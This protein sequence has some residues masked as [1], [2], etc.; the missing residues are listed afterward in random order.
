MYNYINYDCCAVLIIRMAADTYIIIIYMNENAIKNI[1]VATT[2][3]INEWK[4]LWLI[5][6][7]MTLDLCGGVLY[8]SIMCENNT[9]RLKINPLEL[10]TGFTSLFIIT[11]R[12]NIQFFILVYARTIWMN[13]LYAKINK[14]HFFRTSISSYLFEFVKSKWNKHI[15]H[16][17]LNEIS[18]HG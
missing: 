10:D 11:D 6:S 3:A 13:I 9:R 18:R 14:V 7:L 17:R 16:G 2:A 5:D 1:V 8:N 12:L 4:Y 15:A